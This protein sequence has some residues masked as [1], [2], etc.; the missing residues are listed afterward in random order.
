VFG[1]LLFFPG[2]A[3]FFFTLVPFAQSLQILLLCAT[4]ATKSEYPAGGRSILRM[5][6]NNSFRQTILRE[7]GCDEVGLGISSVSEKELV[8]RAFINMKMSV[9]D[10][11]PNSIDCINYL[12]VGSVGCAYNLAKLK[13]SRITH[14]LCL[15][16]AVRLKYPEQFEYLRISIEDHGDEDILGIL[17]E[18]FDFI[19]AAKSRGGRCFVHCYQVCK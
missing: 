3:A 15:S 9:D 4:K 16:D 8:K 13:D 17:T 12:T 10:G 1:Y 5:A 6:S 11:V 18:C 7:Y 19:Q 14:I 2:F